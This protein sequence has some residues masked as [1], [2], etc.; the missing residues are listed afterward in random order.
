[1]LEKKKITTITNNTAYLG[2]NKIMKKQ[3][4]NKNVDKVEL[5]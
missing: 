2:S 4:E 3:K 5:E 1:M